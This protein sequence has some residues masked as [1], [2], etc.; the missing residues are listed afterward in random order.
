MNRTVLGLTRNFSSAAAVISR[1]IVIFAAAE[2]KV[3][4]AA[5]ATAVPFVGVTGITGATAADQRLDVHLDG[6]R[7]IEAGGAF[8]QGVDLTS[9]AEG[10]CIAAAPGANA[11]HRIIGQ[12][13]EASLGVG[14][15]V[16]ARI[17]PGSLSNPA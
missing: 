8:A 10:R 14:Q 11:T 17:A 16:A 6:V 4:Q 7:Q 5:S 13:L 2:G 9:D 1:R 15:F 3:Q 12:A